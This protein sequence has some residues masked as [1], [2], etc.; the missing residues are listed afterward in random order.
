MCGRYGLSSTPARINSQFNVPGDPDLVPNYNG[1]PGTNVLGIYGNGE[2][3]EH[4]SGQAYWGFTPGWIKPG[5]SGIRPI[6]AR[7]ETVTNKSIFR[8]AFKRR[9]CIM[10]TDEFYEWKAL[11]KGKQAWFI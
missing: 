3:D 11:A 10:P 5:R 8:R 4:R 9:C 7:A 6:N 1:A 2:S